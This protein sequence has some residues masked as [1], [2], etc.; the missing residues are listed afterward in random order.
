MIIKFSADIKKYH[1]NGEKTGWS[2]LEVPEAIAVQLHATDRKSFRVKGFLNQTAIK[3]VA[4]V[5][6]G[7]GNY[8]LPLNNTIRTQIKRKVGDVVLVEISKDIAAFELFPPFKDCLQDEPEAYHFF[9]TLS[10]SHQRYFSN[11]IVA[12]KTEATQTKR[13]AM[14]VNALAKKM[15]YPEMIRWEKQQKLNE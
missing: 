12:A 1:E 15:G 3:Q 10:V 7:D 4:L 9:N 13:M 8:I 6:I 11:W 5:P 2:F 14:A